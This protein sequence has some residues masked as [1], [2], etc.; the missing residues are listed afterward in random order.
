M[1]LGTLY[2]SFKDTKGSGTSGHDSTG[3]FTLLNGSTLD[4]APS[5]VPQ[6]VSCTG[7]GSSLSKTLPKA[8]CGPQSAQKT[9][10]RQ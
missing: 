9:A 3:T 4:L 6:M 7:V 5:P 8:P 10:G 2:H 1:Y